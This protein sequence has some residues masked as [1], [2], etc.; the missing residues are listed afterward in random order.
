AL[1]HGLATATPCPPTRLSASIWPTAG[2]LTRCVASTT[3]TPSVLRWWLPYTARQPPTQHAVL[4]QRLVQ[5]QRAH[6][7]HIEPVAFPHKRDANEHLLAAGA[8]QHR[9]HAMHV[10]ADRSNRICSA[11]VRTG[12]LRRC[13]LK[14]E[15]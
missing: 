10:G 5:P 9:P 7:A 8:S 14:R 2:E 4:V 12:G 15:D 11:A 3:G 13:H 1:R 6:A